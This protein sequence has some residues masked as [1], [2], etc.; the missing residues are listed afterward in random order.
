MA[1]ILV[2]ECKKVI[3][4]IIIKCNDNNYC[5]IVTF[6]IAKSSHESWRIIVQ[7]FSGMRLFLSY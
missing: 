7:I 2:L 5:F 1:V 6:M 4:N 3:S